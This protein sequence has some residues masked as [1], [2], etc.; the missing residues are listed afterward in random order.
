MNIFK[1]LQKDDMV[2]IDEWIDGYGVT[3][4]ADKKRLIKGNYSL[5]EN[6]IIEGCEII[7]D[8]AFRQCEKLTNVVIPNTVTSIEWGAFYGCT[9]LTSVSIPNNVKSIGKVAFVRCRNL[10]KITIGNSV[11]SIGNFAFCY[12][13]L[14][15]IHFK[16][17]I[18][19]QIG[20]DSLGYTFHLLTNDCKLYVPKGTKKAY[21]E[22]WSFEN[23]IEE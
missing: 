18:P 16:S 3:Y 12:T 19:P 11:I 22:A 10:S 9:G 13:E 2:N 14:K 5:T 23:I 21:Q 7:N 20:R 1:K 6:P 15:E 8:F 17:Q 4:S